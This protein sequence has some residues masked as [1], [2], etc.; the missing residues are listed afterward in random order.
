NSFVGSVSVPWSRFCQASR[1]PIHVSSSVA[2]AYGVRML[3]QARASEDS[4][5]F[6][7]DPADAGLFRSTSLTLFGFFTS[8]RLLQA[9]TVATRASAPSHGL[10]VLRTPRSD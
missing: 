6:A 7:W 9:A 2:T 3:P 8:S 10:P 4:T 5:P 1:D